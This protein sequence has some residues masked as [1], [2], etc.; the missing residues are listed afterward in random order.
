MRLIYK[1]LINKSDQ[2]ITKFSIGKYRKGLNEKISKLD[3]IYQ[4]EI[5]EVDEMDLKADKNI[6][7]LT[8]AL[9]EKEIKLFGND[10]IKNNKTKSYLIINNKKFD[11]KKLNNIYV[12]NIKKKVDKIKIKERVLDKTINLNSKFEGCISLIN[13]SGLN[14]TEVKSMEKLFYNCKLL[15]FKIENR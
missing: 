2:L 1:G 9:N 11:L 12:H 4:E 14:Q 8:Y 5:Y 3:N 13:I 10:Y 6:I 15:Y 7:K